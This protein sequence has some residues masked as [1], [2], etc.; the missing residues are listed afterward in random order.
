MPAKRA[1]CTLTC[2]TLNFHYQRLHVLNDMR[3][4]STLEAGIIVAILS[5]RALRGSAMA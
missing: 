3:V 2:P 4:N 1:H 5:L